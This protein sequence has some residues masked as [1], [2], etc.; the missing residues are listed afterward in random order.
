MDLRNLGNMEIELPMGR[1]AL[2][3]ITVFLILGLIFLFGLFTMQ[4]SLKLIM[5]KY[6]YLGVFIASFLGST[7]FVPFAI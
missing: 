7:I 5:P 6:G 2:T 1:I 4:E 3:S